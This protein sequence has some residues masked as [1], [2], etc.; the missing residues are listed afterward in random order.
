MA[1]GSQH[2]CWEPWSFISQW[3]GAWKVVGQSVQCS[4]DQE[5]SGAGEGFSRDP[6][7]NSEGYRLPRDSGMQW[8]QRGVVVGSGRNNTSGRRIEQKG[9]KIETARGKC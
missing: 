8:W 1:R 7:W 9:W 4:V 6:G 5:G 2:S 3:A